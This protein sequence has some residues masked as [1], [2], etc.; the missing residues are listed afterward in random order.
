MAD[1]LHEGVTMDE[2]E[3]QRRIAAFRQDMRSKGW[4]DDQIDAVL[5]QVEYADKSA[6]QLGIAYKSAT[7]GGELRMLHAAFKAQRIDPDSP[8]GQALEQLWIDQGLAAA[9]GQVVQV[10]RYKAERDMGLDPRGLRT[11]TGRLIGGPIRDEKGRP[12]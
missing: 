7:P 8:A 5:A 9:L 12:L 2:Q 6:A 11:D 10:A 3:R 1:A 4:S